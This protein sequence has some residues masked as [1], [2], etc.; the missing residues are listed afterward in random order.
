MNSNNKFYENRVWSDDCLVGIDIIDNQHKN[1][2]R[3]LDELVSLNSM[4]DKE[5]EII[6]IINKFE[7]YAAYHF[8]TEE[9]FMD[10]N[11][12]PDIERHKNLHKLFA[13]KIMFFKNEYINGNH[14]ILEEMMDY[15]RKWLLYHILYM[16]VNAIFDRSL[17]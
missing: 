11:N 17:I 1:F 7:Q 5:N 15:A 12:Y 14:E 2:F 8:S 9:G 3:M 16:D 4:K 10:K 13:K 6:Q